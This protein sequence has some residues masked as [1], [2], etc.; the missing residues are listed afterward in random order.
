MTPRAEEI[1]ARLAAVRAQI[2]AIERTFDHDVE[3]MG[4]TKGF[5]ASL[6][7][8]A[9]SAGCG[10]LG[11]NYAQEL[12][13]KHDAFIGSDVCFI[14]Q[15]QTN[16]VRQLAGV[17][18]LWCSVDR[19]RLVDEVAKRSP[20]A[21]VL[22]QVD[23]TGQEG[24]GGCPVDDVPDLVARARD[25]G[26]AV[27]GL[28]NVGPTGQ[29]PE[30]AREGFRATRLLVDELGLRTCSIGMSADLTVAVEEGSTQIRLGTR[31]FGPRPPRAA[32]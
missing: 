19:D 16:K 9:V 29:P 5:D 8:D 15:L 18:D 31:L 7:I 17:V 14:G 6:V 26:L 21:R 22:L 3:I 2:D 11:E 24:K 13:A 20:G 12:L 23:T 25:R 28:M 1:A 30:A 4:V 27:E 32:D 10:P